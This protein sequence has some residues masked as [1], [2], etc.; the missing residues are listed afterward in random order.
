[1][2]TIRWDAFCR[3]H[4]IPKRLP[5]IQRDK[6]SHLPF[7]SQ[8]SSERSILWVLPLTFFGEGGSITKF[9]FVGETFFLCWEQGQMLERLCALLANII[10]SGLSTGYETRGM[11]PNPMKARASI[12]HLYDFVSQKR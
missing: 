8:V 5:N 12:M 11:V 10:K 3:R 1:M 4:H 9:G 6:D 7:F 2:S